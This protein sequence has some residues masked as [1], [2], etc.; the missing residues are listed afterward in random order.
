MLKASARRSKG[1]RSATMALLAV[2][3]CAQPR[4]A[5]TAMSTITSQS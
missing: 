2:M 4:A 3:Y 5:S 1:V